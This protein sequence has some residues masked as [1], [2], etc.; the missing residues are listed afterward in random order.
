MNNQMNNQI[1]NERKKGILAVEKRKYPRYTVEL[2]LDYARIEDKGTYGGMVA[3]VNE[4]GVLVYLPQRLEVGEVLKIEILYIHGLEFN[5]IK[6]VAKIVWSDLAAKESYGEYRYG[7]QFIHIE[8]DE[9]NRLLNLLK[10][11]GK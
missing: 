6:A 5:T 10:E 7:L 4:G 1:N 8:E 2:P 3:N 9:Y 11:I